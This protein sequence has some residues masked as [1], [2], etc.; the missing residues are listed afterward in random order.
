MKRIV[1]LLLMMCLMVACGDPDQGPPLGP[2][3]AITKKETDPAFDIT[4]PS[5]RSPAA[6]TFTSSNTAV[7]TIAGT[8]VTIKGPGETTI[9]ASQ[10]RIGS[11]GPTSASTT[12]TVSKVD[13]GAGSVVVDGKC[14]VVPT[15]V[16]PAVL[17]N[18]QCVPPP[19]SAAVVHFDGFA[20]MGVSSTDNFANAGNFCAT[21]TIGGVTGWK[22]PTADQ[23]IALQKSSALAGQGWSLGATW[24]STLPTS[25]T[26]ASH[27]VVDLSTGAVSAHP[28]VGIAY[29]SCVR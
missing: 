20:W 18:N 21:S 4:P 15:C 9:T 17:S 1:G 27:M 7:A 24:S 13:C 8:L 14:A 19:T 5:S 6:F 26:T 10:P 2:F 11:F 16:A 22:Q 29:V 25:S 3:A 28:D 23:L 12:L